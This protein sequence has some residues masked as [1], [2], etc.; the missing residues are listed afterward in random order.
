M[1]YADPMTTHDAEPLPGEDAPLPMRFGGAPVT[2]Q[3]ALGVARRLARAQTAQGR[4]L[5][6]LAEPTV[7]PP[8]DARLV[9]SAHRMPPR[10]LMRARAKAE[11]EGVTLTSVIT[12]ALEAYASSPPGAKPAFVLPGGITWGG[13]P[14]ASADN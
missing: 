4:K 10:L 6:N 14:A 13:S 5:S 12:A 2:D 1:A 3:E 9:Q 11:M 7:L 8:A